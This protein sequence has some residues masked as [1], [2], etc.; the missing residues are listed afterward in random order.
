MNTQSISLLY[1]T[2]AEENA[3]IFQSTFSRYY[4]VL[5]ASSCETALQVLKQ[6]SVDVVVSDQKLSDESGLEFLRKSQEYTPD[7]MRILM[8]Y[9]DELQEIADKLRSVQI[10]RYIIQPWDEHDIRLTIDNA[11]DHLQLLREARALHEDVMQHNERLKQEVSQRTQLL[12]KKSQELEK[13][14]AEIR[15]LNISLTELHNEKTRFLELATND[16]KHPVDAIHHIIDTIKKHTTHTSHPHIEESVDELSAIVKKIQEILDNIVAF[17][18]S[19]VSIS[20]NPM[21]FDMSMI[22]QVIDMNYREAA[23]EKDIIIE[24]VR[25]PNVSMIHTDPSLV[26]TIL[27]HLVSNAVK[28]SSP[29]TTIT[30]VLSQHDN[31][32][33]CEVHDEGPGIADHE[34]ELVFMPY[35]KLSALPTG[36]ESGAGIGLALVKNLVEALHGKIWFE[37]RDKG[38]TFFV[39]LP[40][41]HI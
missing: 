39:E 26:Q 7:S 21:L 2:S 37:N 24:F 32:L 27:D 28:F 25:N 29:H 5:S 19:Q 15:L 35:A 23:K 30:T 12:E 17:N 18:Q 1:V 14:N 6:T 31:V 41:F 3:R 16:I 11:Y 36:G 9:R 22:M 38:V 33:R 10:F 4:H 13:V 20:V 8:T 34:R 40:P